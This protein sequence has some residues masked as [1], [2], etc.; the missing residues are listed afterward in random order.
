MAGLCE[1]GNE[2]PSSLKAKL[3]V[4]SSQFFYLSHSSSR[5]LEPQT[6]RDSSL[7]SNSGPQ[8]RSTALE[9][10]SLQ[11]RSTALELRPSDADADADAHSSRT[12]ACLLWLTH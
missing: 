7:Y 11:L 4:L 3:P 10:R 8:L 2:P 12:L 9:L 1:G 5:Y 6:F